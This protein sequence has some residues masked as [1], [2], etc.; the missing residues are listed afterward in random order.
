MPIVIY[1]AALAIASSVP[2]LAW[3]VGGSIRSN[4]SIRSNLRIDPSRFRVVKPKSLGDQITSHLGRFAPS[5]YR[6]DIQHRLDKSGQASTLSFERYLGIKVLVMIVTAG[7]GVVVGAWAG[8]VSI[9]MMPIL[10]TVAGWMLPDFQLDGMARARTEAIEIQLPDVLDQLTISIE[11]GLGYEAALSRLVATSDG[12]I[13]EEFRRVLQDIRLGLPRD[14][15]LQ[16]LADRSESK[17]LR[18]FASALAQ[19]TRHGLPITSVL[20]AQASEAREKRRYRAEE[21]AMKIPVKV[22]G[23]LIL[24]ILPTLFIILMGPAAIRISD[25]GLGG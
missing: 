3:S 18:N 4:R 24:C 22:L 11:A 23:P 8:S 19:S 7:I 1:L 5:G 25:A 21:K 16:A 17:D 15:A 20:R 12:P 6:T 10:F 14:G 2:I 13:I 9:W